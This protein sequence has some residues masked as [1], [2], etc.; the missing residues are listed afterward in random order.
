MSRVIE[1]VGPGLIDAA[2]APAP[3]LIQGKKVIGLA[4][5][6]NQ[7]AGS[8]E[9]ITNELTPFYRTVNG[10]EMGNVFEVLLV[11]PDE[12]QADFDACR[13]AAPCPAFAKNDP[14]IKNLLAWHKVK[15]LPTLCVIAED[16]TEITNEGVKEMNPP[17]PPPAGG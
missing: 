7:S 12:E 3:D 15:A 10:S 9:W 14:M 8:M 4:F 5:A 11:C 6:S 13:A 1:Y 2:G 16:A 17:P